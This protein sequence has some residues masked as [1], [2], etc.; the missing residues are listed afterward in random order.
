MR[1]MQKSCALP[2][3]PSHARD[4]DD[5]QQM[6]DGIAKGS[7]AGAGALT[8]WIARDEVVRAAPLID[9][10]ALRDRGRKP[11]R[12]LEREREPLARIL[13]QADREDA[14]DVAGEL[15]EQRGS[16]RRP[17]DGVVQGRRYVLAADHR[18]AG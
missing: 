15:R 12:E 3:V 2:Q 7:R 11:A 14:V 17:V 5:R 1:A 18:M 9:V 13:G 4:V 6:Q 16:R 8:P 10:E